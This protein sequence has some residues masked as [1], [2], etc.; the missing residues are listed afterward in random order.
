[1]HS[2]VQKEHM[3]D[4][5]DKKVERFFVSLKAEDRGGENDM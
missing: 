1:M 5:G 4:C 2:A 3:P